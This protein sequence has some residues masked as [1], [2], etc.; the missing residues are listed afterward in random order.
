MAQTILSLRSTIQSHLNATGDRWLNGDEDPYGW[1][2]GLGCWLE[3]W[4][5]PEKGVEGKRQHLTL[6]ILKVVLD[7][8]L[9][10]LVYKGLYEFAYVEIYDSDWGHVGTGFVSPNMPPSDETTSILAL[11]RIEGK[12]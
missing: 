3:F 8:L 2:I 10:R 5:N 7:G 1:E 12:R 4:S 11:L 9:Q 6:G